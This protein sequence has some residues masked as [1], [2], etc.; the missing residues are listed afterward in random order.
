MFDYRAVH[1][2]VSLSDLSVYPI[3]SHLV[4]RRTVL[5]ETTTQPSGNGAAFAAPEIF[6]TLKARVESSG[7]QIVTDYSARKESQRNG[8]TLRQSNVATEHH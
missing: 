2:W 1:T 8:F 3:P 6:K 5:L 7:G 4:Y